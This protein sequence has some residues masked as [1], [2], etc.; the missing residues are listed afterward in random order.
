MYDV[1]NYC[2]KPV[3]LRQQQ[4]P[5]LFVLLICTIHAIPDI[6]IVV[7]VVSV[8]FIVV[9]R[10]YLYYCH[11]LP[12]LRLLLVKILVWIVEVRLENVVSCHV[13]WR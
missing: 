11:Y 10:S 2:N 12:V 6:T 13:I 7:A 9:C 1:Y 3:D 8:L 5:K 4:L